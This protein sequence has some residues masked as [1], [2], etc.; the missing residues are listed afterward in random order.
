MKQVLTRIEIRPQIA[1]L[2]KR[3]GRAKLSKLRLQQ[4][5]REMLLQRLLHAAKQANLEK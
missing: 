5:P 1:L 3:H 2:H 4:T